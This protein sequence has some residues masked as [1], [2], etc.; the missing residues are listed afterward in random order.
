MTQCKSNRRAIAQLFTCLLVRLGGAFRS[1]VR[2]Q[3]RIVL[4]NMT[5]DHHLVAKRLTVALRRAAFLVLF[6]AMTIASTMALAEMD[7]VP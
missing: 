6:T 5:V 7:P 4:I 3:V 2:L 1:G